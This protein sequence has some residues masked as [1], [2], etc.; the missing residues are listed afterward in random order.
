[1]DI[2]THGMMGVAIAGP[3]LGTETGCAVGFVLGS[4]LP[5]LDSLSRCFGKRAF[6]EWHQGWT[7]S[8]PVQLLVGT[9][10]WGLSRWLLP[11][12]AM[13]AIG[14]TLGAIL[15]SL[16]DL[17]NT[18][19]IRIVA[20]FSQRRFCFEWIF[21]IDSVVVLLTIAALVPA[22]GSLRFGWEPNPAAS[23]LFVLSLLAYAGCKAWLRRRAGALAA[24]AVAVIPSALF[25]WIFFTCEHS[26]DSV[27]SS[28]LNAL[29]GKSTPLAR[30]TI[31]DKEFADR[32][33][34]LPEYRA[35]SSLSPAY[36][37]VDRHQELDGI[38]I[39]CRDVRIVN[40]DTTFGNLDVTFGSGPEPVSVHLHV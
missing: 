28:R 1:M 36:H 3:F 16:L 18:Y 23:G 26:A 27:T 10:A 20:P 32:L 22:I 38:H 35:M 9:V 19:G 33:S 24:D 5:D 21:F 15:H 8:L 40:F 2:V 34:K 37:V 4:A 31:F 14:L 13:V 17:T 11:D 6:L 7:H 29:T 39:R 30:H 12:F 25:P